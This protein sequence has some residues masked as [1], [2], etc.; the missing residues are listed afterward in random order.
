VMVDD[1]FNL[2]VVGPFDDEGRFA[3]LLVA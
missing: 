2:A 3:D 1:G